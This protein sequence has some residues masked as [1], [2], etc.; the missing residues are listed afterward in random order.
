MPLYGSANSVYWPKNN[1]S[2]AFWVSEDDLLDRRTKEPATYAEFREAYKYTSLQDAKRQIRLITVENERTQMRYSRRFFGDNA[3]RPR[4]SPVHDKSVLRCSLRVVNIYN[5]GPCTEQ[6]HALSYVWGN[7]K[8]QLPILVDGRVKAIPRRLRFALEDLFNEMLMGRIEK[9]PVWADAIS[10][11][12]S[13]AQEKSDQIPLMGAIYT[14]ASRVIAVPGYE[15]REE[16]FNP[17]WTHP[18]KLVEN[19][20][21]LCDPSMQID[22]QHFPNSDAPFD[23]QGMSLSDIQKAFLDNELPSDEDL[24][25]TSFGLF[26]FVFEMNWWRRAWIRQELSLCDAHRAIVLYEGGSVTWQTLVNTTRWLDRV[27]EVFG[28]NS[29]LHLLHLVDEDEQQ[30]YVEFATALEAIKHFRDS[31]MRA[32]VDSSRSLA[33]ILYYTYIHIPYIAEAPETQSIGAGLQVDHIYALLALATGEVGTNIT[34]DYALSTLQVFRQVTI[35]TLRKHGGWTFQCMGVKPGSQN[36]DDEWPSWV[37]PW[38]L[39]EHRRPFQ[40]RGTSAENPKN[41][42]LYYASGP[43]SRVPGTSL[44]FE[45]NDDSI[46]LSGIKVGTVVEARSVIPPSLR[47]SPDYNMEWIQQ[48]DLHVEEMCATYG[49]DSDC[50]WR[51]PIANQEESPNAL[52]PLGCATSRMRDAY[53]S[54]LKSSSMNDP[55]CV[56]YV[57][58]MTAIFGDE[59]MQVFVLNSGRLGI[60]GSFTNHD[61]IYII[62]GAPMPIILRPSQRSHYRFIGEVYVQGIMDGEIVNERT[63]RETVVID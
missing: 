17:Y 20:R 57:R 2:T 29:F 55:E 52:Q 60:G 49:I 10:I 58:T 11:D 53:N 45:I 21:Q 4:Y 24:K 5:T 61:A 33:S 34:P 31:S 30:T 1:E 40:V 54:L 47:S 6:Y 56:E 39:Q 14:R 42:S 7:P 48:F 18:Y 32:E 63:E 28:F 43:K 19:F 23:R 62:E 35:D 13:S 26:R 46:L 12:Q 50:K 22:R 25:E 37:I 3:K 16:R 51:L 9:L 8:Q 15:E 27:E 38:G 44:N 36:H 59:R 41:R